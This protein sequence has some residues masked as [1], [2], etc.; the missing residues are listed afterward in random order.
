MPRSRAKL[1]SVRRYL[2]FSQNHGW[3]CDNVD[4]FELVLAKSSIVN[5]SKSQHPDFFWA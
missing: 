1:I 4:E 2:F 3:A 5:V